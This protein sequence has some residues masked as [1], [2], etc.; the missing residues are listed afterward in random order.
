MARIRRARPADTDA[1]L[2]LMAELGRPAVAQDP[3]PQRQVFL[4]HLERRDAAV[5]VAEADGALTGAASLWFRPRLN[6][7]TLE[8]WLADLVV[9]PQARRRGVA[10]ALLDACVHEARSAGCHELKLES[11]HHRG[12]AHRLYESYGFAHAGRAYRLPL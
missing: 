10:R 7:T 8:A 12:A 2:A 11:A 3:E 5:L 4:A 6:W 1:V 9:A